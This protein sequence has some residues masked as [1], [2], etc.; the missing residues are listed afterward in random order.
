MSGAV[1]YLGPI[2]NQILITIKVALWL[3]GHPW[4]LRVPELF[5]SLE[6][7]DIGCSKWT[8]PYNVSHTLACYLNEVVL[9]LSASW[10]NAFF[11]NEAIQ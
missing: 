2:D 3:Y 6:Q 10:E 11:E 7:C 8:I 1:K 9:I 5:L 4:I